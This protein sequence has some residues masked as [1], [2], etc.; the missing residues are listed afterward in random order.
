MEASDDPIRRLYVLHVIGDLDL[1]GAETLLYRLVSAPTPDVQ[2]EVI[3]LGDPG[4]YSEGLAEQ[5][6]PVHHLGMTSVWSALTRIGHLRRLIGTSGADVA[7]SW[8]YLA[9]V[10]T[11]F[12]ARR[13]RIPVVWG[14]HG[15]TLD[16]VGMASQLCAR[17]GGAGA[18]WLSSFVINCS[19]RS[20]DLHRRLGYSAVPGAVV[21]N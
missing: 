8:M 4:W 11:G 7:Q 10:L 21:P 17:I 14:I 18:R 19:Q 5:G 6:I 9:N 3:C 16:H 15:A 2:H 1:G 13:A 12:L 20:A